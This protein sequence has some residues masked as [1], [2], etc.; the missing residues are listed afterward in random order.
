MHLVTSSKIYHKDSSYKGQ[1]CP[2]A[3]APPSLFSQVYVWAK[4]KDEVPDV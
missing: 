1:F 2:K 3:R 4:Y